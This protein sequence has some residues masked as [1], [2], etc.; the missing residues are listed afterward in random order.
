MWLKLEMKLRE[1]AGRPKLPMYSGPAS[2]ICLELGAFGRGPGFPL[3]NSREGKEEIVKIIIIIMMMIMIIKQ[4][5][6]S[7]SIMETR[8]KIDFGGA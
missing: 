1:S 3:E 5:P 4:P 7:K 8:S 2:T 6:A